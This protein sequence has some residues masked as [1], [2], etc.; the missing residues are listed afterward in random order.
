VVQSGQTSLAVTGTLKWDS[1]NAQSRMDNILSSYYSDGEKVDAVLAAAD[2]LALGIIS[3]LDSMGYGQSS[4][5]PFPVVVGQDCEITAIKSILAGKQSMSVFLDAVVLAN[6]VLTLVEALEAGQ[7]PVI[8]ATY[9]ND[10]IDV[11]TA[12]YEPVLI[13]ADNYTILIDRE[14]YTEKDLA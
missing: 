11:P 9:N 8:D 12:L 4:D 1:A 10:V 6:K 7:E 2:C 13:T 5:M 3:S 14:F